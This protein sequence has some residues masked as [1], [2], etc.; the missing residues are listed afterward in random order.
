MVKKL[1]GLGIQAASFMPTKFGRLPIFANLRNHRKILVVD[2]E[3]GFTGG[4]N[5]R[6][7]HWLGLKP[8]YPTQCLHFCLR[9]PIVSHLQE[10][11]VVDWSFATS[12]QLSGENWFPVLNRCGNVWARGVAH[13]PDEDFETLS[14]IIF[15]ALASAQKRIRIVTPYFIPDSRLMESLAVASLKSRCR[16]ETWASLIV[17]PLSIS[18]RFWVRPAIQAVLLN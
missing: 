11:F 9:G 2:G 16:S 13:G 7:A 12:E 10:A 1:N 17:T 4:T 14:K 8:D 15:A 18:T 3:I 6:E 5:I